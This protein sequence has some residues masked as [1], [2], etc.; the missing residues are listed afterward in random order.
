M[1]DEYEGDCNAEERRLQGEN[2]A[3]EK[4]T[5]RRPTG[6]CRAKLTVTRVSRGSL[7]TH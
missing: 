6:R 3:L 2:Y 7:A 5:F 1:G 4:K